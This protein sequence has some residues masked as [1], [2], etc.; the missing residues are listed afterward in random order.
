MESEIE[1]L[2]SPKEIEESLEY[3]NK[4]KGLIETQFLEDHNPH[5]W[6]ESLPKDD[7]AHNDKT[8]KNSKGKNDRI[9]PEETK[10]V[11]NWK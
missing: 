5:D 9:E 10:K 4:G 2:E 11:K 7:E 8:G 3:E 6:T 1:N